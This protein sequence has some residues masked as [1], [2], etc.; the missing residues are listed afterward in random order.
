[1]RTAGTIGAL[2]RGT[3]VILVARMM[4]MTMAAAAM[5]SMIPMM[6]AVRLMHGFEEALLCGRMSAQQGDDAQAQRRPAVHLRPR[7]RVRSQD[8]AVG[9]Y[10]EYI[11]PILWNDAAYTHSSYTTSSKRT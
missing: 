1:M 8:E 5:L 3:G 4:V 7:R 9:F 6:L 11:E 2:A 10:I